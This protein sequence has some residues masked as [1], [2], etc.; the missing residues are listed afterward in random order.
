M[1]AEGAEAPGQ[2]RG[3]DFPEALDAHA[4]V[5]GNWHGA[6]R[7]TG[8]VPRPHRH[9]ARRQRVHEGHRQ[10]GEPAVVHSSVDVG[11]ADK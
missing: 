11:S 8:A 6:P 3:D 4:S 10:G 7:W 1:Q 2:V 9:P 5:D